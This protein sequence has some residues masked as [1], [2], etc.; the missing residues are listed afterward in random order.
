[1]AQHKKHERKREIDRRR[2]RLKERNRARAKEAHAV[3]GD[4]KKA[5]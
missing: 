2:K 3:G 5:K 1:M 4:I